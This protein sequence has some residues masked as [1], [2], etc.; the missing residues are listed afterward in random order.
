MRVAAVN[1]TMKAPT[2]ASVLHTKDANGNR[3]I[4]GRFEGNVIHEDPRVVELV[5]NHT[6]HIYGY[7]LQHTNKTKRQTTCFPYWVDS[8][9]FQNADF[10]PWFGKWGQVGGCFYDDMATGTVTVNTAESVTL[11]W[12]VN[13]GADFGGLSLVFGYQ[14]GQQWQNC[15]DS[16]TCWKQDLGQQTG[17]AFYNNVNK[18]FVNSGVAGGNWG[19]NSGC[20]DQ[21]CNNQGRNCCYYNSA[22]QAGW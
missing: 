22:A 13:A 19:C 8:A 21:T 1:E 15:C 18:P 9:Y 14:Y 20:Q 17:Y 7:D 5:N 3:I 2:P 11:T 4:L 16:S 6:R 12:S 10:Y